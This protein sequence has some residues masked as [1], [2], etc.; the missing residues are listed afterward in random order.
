MIK[1]SFLKGYWAAPMSGFFAARTR[2]YPPRE[3]KKTRNEDVPVDIDPGRQPDPGD[4]RVGRRSQR[5]RDVDT[6]R[7]AN[8]ARRGAAAPE[9]G[10]MT[11][12]MAGRRVLVVGGAAG[13][14]R[15]TVRLC[16]EAGARVGVIDR[17][18]WRDEG[19]DVAPTL[20]LRADVRSAAEVNIGVSATAAGLGGLDGIIYCVG[21]DLVAK[22]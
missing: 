6:P 2:H 9:V 14:G 17:D 16:L 19:D 18:L 10:A 1:I 22:L 5:P 7:R 12:A 8:R 20:T 4:A 11:L 13:I 3:R 15:A 21:V